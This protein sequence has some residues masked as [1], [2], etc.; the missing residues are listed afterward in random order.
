MSRPARVVKDRGDK[1]LAF[2][3]APFPHGIQLIFKKYDYSKL[4][5]GAENDRSVFS[6]VEEKGLMAIELPM[7]SGLTDSTGIT[8]NSMERTFTETFI[9]DTVAPMLQSGGG[10]IEGVG[11]GLFDLGE[12]GVKGLANMLTSAKTDTK[13]QADIVAQGS[14][15]LSFL[16]SNTLN[17]FSPGLGKTMGAS[18][19]TAINPQTTLAFEGVNLRQ[20][21][22]N[23]TLYP[24]ST[25]EAESIK[26]IVRAMKRNILPKVESVLGTLSA[27]DQESLNIGTGAGAVLSRAFLA[28]PAT[29]SINLLGV[30]E[31]HF[32]QFKPVMCSNMTVDYGASGEIIIAQGGVPQGIKLS[33]EFKELEIQTAEDYE[34]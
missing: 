5:I 22:L 29:I 31:S 23:W 3:E 4:A 26:Q 33:M 18:R 10:G 24:E 2:P 13:E 1:R 32:L 14:R 9:A 15:V 7:P 17:T 25:E 12:S 6:N 19:G 28:Y 30:D 8:V 16:M 27:A 11:K 34:D 21:S 20:F